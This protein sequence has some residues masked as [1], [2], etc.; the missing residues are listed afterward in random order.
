MT[1]RDAGYQLLWFALIL[2]F[3]ATVGPAS[4]QSGVSEASRGTARKLGSIVGNHSSD[5]P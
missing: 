2:Y 5:R 3:P 4:N 1:Y